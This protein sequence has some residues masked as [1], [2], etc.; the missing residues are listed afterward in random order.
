M[1]FEQSPRDC[2]EGSLNL[3]EPIA[4]VPVDWNTKNRN[5][6]GCPM[7]VIP[8]FSAVSSL[9]LVA[10]WKR[11][12]RRIQ[13]GQRRQGKMMSI[14]LLRSLIDRESK[15]RL[16]R[17]TNPS[18]LPI[19]VSDRPRVGKSTASCTRAVP[20]SFQAHPV[21]QFDPASV[22]ERQQANHTGGRK[23]KQNFRFPVIFLN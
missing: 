23:V 11:R 14:E 20:R 13:S 6:S 1:E 19:H 8:A 4:M 15:T 16:A 18:S 3:M 2:I 12:R 21:L 9:R 17:V 5:P 10:R 7:L 22:P